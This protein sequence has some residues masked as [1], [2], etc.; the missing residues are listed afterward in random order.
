MLRL[1]FIAV[2]SLGCR[3]LRWCSRPRRGLRRLL[4]SAEAICERYES[5]SAY[6]AVT[7]STGMPWLRRAEVTGPSA[8]G[9]M[10]VSTSS[11]ASS[12]PPT[13]P[14]TPR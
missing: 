5:S 4:A 2:P 9:V 3:S 7:L 11:H 8:R 14:E 13:S 10:V 6:P 12:T 1:D